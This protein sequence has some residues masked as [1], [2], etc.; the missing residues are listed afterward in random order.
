MCDIVYVLLKLSLEICLKDLNAGLVGCLLG[1]GVE[2]EA[3]VFLT[4]ER[5]V[6]GIQTRSFGPPHST[7]I[8][9]D[10]AKSFDFY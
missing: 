10:R 9:F 8:A 7:R 4:C 6:P 2:S 5:S 3:V 1:F